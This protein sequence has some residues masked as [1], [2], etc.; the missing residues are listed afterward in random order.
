MDRGRLNM[1]D[2][3]V[4]LSFWAFFFTRVHGII[5]SFCLGFYMYVMPQ[6]NQELELIHDIVAVYFGAKSILDHLCFY[7]DSIYVME[8]ML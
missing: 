8:H 6:C 3:F 4:S 7:S 2:M 5:L 1:V